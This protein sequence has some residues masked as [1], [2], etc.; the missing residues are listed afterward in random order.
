MQPEAVLLKAAE[1]ASDY[2][3]V[4]AMEYYNWKT[5]SW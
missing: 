1:N 3:A 4:Q 5:Y 2:Y